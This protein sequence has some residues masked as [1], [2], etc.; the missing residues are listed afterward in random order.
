MKTILSVA[1]LLGVMASQPVWAGEGAGD[2]FPPNN[3]AVSTTMAMKSGGD[4]EYFKW[5]ALPTPSQYTVHNGGDDEYFKWT[6]APS[7]AA[8]R[9]NVAGSGNHDAGARNPS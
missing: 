6:A 8:P 1:T 5:T 2:P 9:S 7:P 4:D 3:P